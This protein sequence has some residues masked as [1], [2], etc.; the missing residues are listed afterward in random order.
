[1]QDNENTLA[2]LDYRLSQIEKGLSDLTNVILKTKLQERDI[3]DL[4][5]DTESLEQ[6]INSHDKRLRA[7]EIAPVK[8][9]AS[10]FDKAI[11]IIYKLAITGI[12]GM[13]VCKLGLS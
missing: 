2:A 13:V 11:D 5:K 9:K 7:I 10:W 1:M 4:R 3:Q 12:L 6:A 8:S